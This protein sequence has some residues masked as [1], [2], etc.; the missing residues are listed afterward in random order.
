[1]ALL[2]SGYNRNAA[3]R[4]N[5]FKWIGDSAMVSWGRTTG[6]PTGAD[7][8]DG[9]DGN[10]PRYNVIEFNFGSEIGVWEKQSSLYMQAKTSDS[11]INANVGFNGPRAGVNFNESVLCDAAHFATCG[12]TPCISPSLPSFPCPAVGLAA[13]RRSSTTPCLTSAGRVAT[14]E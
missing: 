5:E 2:L 4:G 14:T 1:M 9:T 11:Y 13:T 3:I 12:D 6:D 10:Q 8:W 7:G